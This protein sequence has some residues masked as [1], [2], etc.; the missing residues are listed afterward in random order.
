MGN[1]EVQGVVDASLT[2]VMVE[3]KILSFLFKDNDKVLDH[4][5]DWLNVSESDIF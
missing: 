5:G 1:G 3:E 2:P 4:I